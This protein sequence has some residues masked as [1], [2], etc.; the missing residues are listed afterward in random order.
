[1]RRLQGLNRLAS[2]KQ[3]GSGEFN[4]GKTARE[5]YAYSV[6]M[7][8]SLIRVSNVLNEMTN[9]PTIALF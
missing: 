8:T 4:P 6:G 5:R 1:M 7:S 2:C 9:P 3:A